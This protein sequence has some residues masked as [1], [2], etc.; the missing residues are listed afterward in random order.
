MRS[1][2]AWNGWHA[3]RSPSSGRR[4]GRTRRPS[5]TPDSAMSRW[6]SRPKPP[7]PWRICGTS[8]SSSPA[9]SSREPE[10]EESP[11]S[12][13]EDLAHDVL[14]RVAEFLRKVPAEQLAELAAGEARLEV[15][16]KG[17]RA[18]A[19]KAAPAALPR[20]AVEIAA[21]MT[22]IGDRLAARRYLETDL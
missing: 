16:P 15:V 7:A 12:Q 1:G 10:C 20:P 19:R 3:S 14:I 5:P 22:E 18:P 2:R 6:C 8:C 11:V 13:P 21:T 9:S 4:S 17:G